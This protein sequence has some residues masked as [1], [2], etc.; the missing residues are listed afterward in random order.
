MPS[1]PKE[2]GALP[3]APWPRRGAP[4]HCTGASPS[5]RGC[6]GAS[7]PAAVAPAGGGRAGTQ[8]E[9]AAA[10][11]GE[12]CAPPRPGHGA[13]R[14]GAL[15]SAARVCPGCTRGHGPAAPK[16]LRRWRIRGCALPDHLALSCPAALPAPRLHV[17]LRCS[18]AARS[19]VSPSALLGVLSPLRV[20]SPFPG[21]CHPAS[22]GVEQPLSVAARPGQ[23]RGSR[24]S[25]WVLAGL[26]GLAAPQGGQ[27]H[28]PVPRALRAARPA[29]AEAEPEAPGECPPPAAVLPLAKLL[30][31]IASVAGCRPLC[32]PSTVPFRQATSVLNLFLLWVNF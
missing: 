1:E 16:D 4:G 24:A 18:G 19:P 28:E 8:R 10:L 11:G 31:E 14:V 21:D 2:H 9:V 13:R 20:E 27:R 25:L 29:G 7:C 32:S 12:A 6:P 23:A 26:R 17:A 15:L 30:S 3:R 22:L 5:L